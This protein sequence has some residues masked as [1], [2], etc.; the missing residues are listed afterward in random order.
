MKK[1]KKKLYLIGALIV[2]LV[3]GAFLTFR[4]IRT[5]NFKKDINTASDKIIK[6]QDNLI[7]NQKLLKQPAS[8][9]TTITS[10]TSGSEQITFNAKLDLN[11][12]LTELALNPSVLGLTNP[13]E[14]YIH[15]S[16]KF[17]KNSDILSKMYEISIDTTSV[18]CEAG[19]E[20]SSSSQI[21][22]SL[23][24]AYPKDQ[25]ITLI[26]HS[27]SLLNNSI[28]IFDIK[29]TNKDNTYS[30]EYT[31][32]INTKTLKK[33]KKNFTKDTELT[34]TFYNLF[35]DYL[36]KYNITKDNLSTIFDNNITGFIKVAIDKDNQ[37]TYIIQIDNL[38][39]VTF[40]DNDIS[41]DFTINF[42]N[43][44]NLYLKLNKSENK[45][46]FQLEKGTD[47]LIDVSLDSKDILNFQGTL[48]LN[49][50]EYNLTS[51][52][53]ITTSD[54]T[55]RSG[56]LKVNLNNKDYTITYKLTYL[57]EF[58]KSIVSDYENYTELTKED[59][60]NID[61][62]LAKLA[63]SSLLKGLLTP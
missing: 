2:L 14:F 35:K 20:C 30:K 25:I 56:T 31:Y 43:S 15:N 27:K 55:G 52:D 11:N 38:F 47:K 22:N 10:P 59:L 33:L 48:S 42:L 34:S 29:T 13:I 21:L 50:K 41:S 39:T 26:N 1:E 18:K 61:N 4:V 5:N 36:E 12:H 57:E 16:R 49:K 17:L 51:I 44:Y 24:L 58:T 54:D 23:N 28:G 19:L 53:T 7:N 6:T 40:T 32:Q 45:L 8:I 63:S 62:A 46:S 37:K 9:E 3:I 60:A